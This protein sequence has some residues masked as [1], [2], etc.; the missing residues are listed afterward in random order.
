MTLLRLC[1]ALIAVTAPQLALAQE[2]P[3]EY[4]AFMKAVERSGDFK[5]GVLKVNVPRND[6][7]V[8]ISGRPAPTPFGFGGWLAVTAGDGGMHVMMGDL[9]LTEAEVNPVMSALL[10]N[11]LEVTALHNHFFHEQPRIFYLHVHGAGTP[12]DLARR[13][14]PAL[15]LIGRPASP[16]TQ[17]RTVAPARG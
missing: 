16:G 7:E 3:A 14:R 15:G 6:L 2:M 12:D 13:A 5:D 8:T 17:S 11:G 10:D 9:V 4:S 1:L